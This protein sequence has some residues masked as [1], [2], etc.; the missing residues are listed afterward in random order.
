MSR[1][2][3]SPYFLKERFKPAKALRN[4]GIDAGPIPCNDRIS[5]SVNFESC[6]RD[7]IPLFSRARRAGAESNDKKP[8]AGFLSLSH[9]GHVGQSEVF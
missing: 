5:F 2:Y 7:D 1:F 4:T 6:C 9:I 3:T 8:V